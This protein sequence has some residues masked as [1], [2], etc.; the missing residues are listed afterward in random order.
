M[1][2]FKKPE[3]PPVENMPACLQLAQTQPDL[4]DV[5]LYLQEILNKIYEIEKYIQDKKEQ[6]ENDTNESHAV[7]HET[8]DQLAHT[9]HEIKEHALIELIE[10]Y[11]ALTFSYRNQVRQTEKNNEKSAHTAK[12]LLLEALSVFMQEVLATEREINQ[13]K[14]YHFLGKSRH[15]TDNFGQQPDY[16]INLLGEK[17]TLAL[18]KVEFKNQF[19]YSEFEKTRYKKTPEEMLKKKKSKPL[20]LRLIPF[21]PDLLTHTEHEQEGLKGEEASEKEM[22]T[23]GHILTTFLIT[24]ISMPGIALLLLPYMSETVVTVIC[25][26]G[27]ALALGAFLGFASHNGKKQ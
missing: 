24:W 10:G 8:L 20:I 3:S 12:E 26:T 17:E 23:N 6:R 2:I 27:W 9:V 19:D 1:K 14:A 5:T 13:M 15:L 4:Q 25:L 22:K 7:L 18:E 16:R 21:N 11:C